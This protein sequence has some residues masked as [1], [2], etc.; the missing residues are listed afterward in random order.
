MGAPVN[1]TGKR[2][3][4]LVVVEKSTP[5]ISPCGT[6]STMWLCRCDC[7]N[8]VTAFAQNLV[9]GSTRSC[10]CYNNEAR[11]NRSKT[12]GETE[13]RLYGIWCGMKRRCHNESDPKYPQYGMRGIV[14]CDE[15]RASYEAFRDWSVAH[16]YDDGL[17]IDRIDNEKGYDPD[18]CR[19]TT[20][21][22]QANNR[23]STF[24][25][26]HDG[27]DLPLSEWARLTGIKYH[28]LYARL[29]SGWSVGKAFTTQ[30]RGS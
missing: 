18:N 27:K 8:E 25:V 20:A 15:W 21:I 22:V 10:G 4:R 28:T 24:F 11:S 16:G 17:T 30:A 12:H 3:G 7:G 23:R 1:L 19:W 29:A 2:F 14:V 13:T 6:R 26:A 5:H 9:R